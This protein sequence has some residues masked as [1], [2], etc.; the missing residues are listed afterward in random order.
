MSYDAREE[1]ITYMNALGHATNILIH[2]SKGETVDPREIIKLARKIAFV[3]LNPQVD[4]V[5]E[6]IGQ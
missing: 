3:A 6:E 4:K 1:R 2:N 5:R